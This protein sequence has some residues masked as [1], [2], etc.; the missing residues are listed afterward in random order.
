MHHTEP[1]TVSALYDY[2]HVSNILCTKQTQYIT[3]NHLQWVLSMITNMSQIYCV[4]NKH[5]T[6]HCTIYSGCSLWLR[7][8]LKYTLYQT[9]TIHHTEP[10][11]VSVLYDY[12]HVSNILCTKQ[13]QYITLNHLQW[14]F[15]MIT[16]M[17]Q[18][19]C[20]PNKHNT[21]HCTIYSGCSLWL[22]TCLK[23][24]VYQTNTIHHTEPFTVSVLYDY[25]HVSNILCTKQTQY[26]TLDHLQWV[27]SMITNMS[28]IHCVPNK[29][30]TSHWTIYSECSLWL[31]TCLKYTVYQ[32][33]TIH[34]TE[35]FTVSAL[36][37]YEHVS[38]WHQ[39][40]PKNDRK[41]GTAADTISYDR[42]L[43]HLFAL[44]WLSSVEYTRRTF[45][46]NPN[47]LANSGPHQFV[48]HSK[49]SQESF[50][51]WPQPI[52]DDVTR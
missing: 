36:Y 37:D 13:T 33:N 21:S 20:V 31:R 44:S 26:I 5:N 46:D 28:Q 3:L 14:V 50:W 32:T 4:P 41:K 48:L 39:N 1:F 42:C 27:F 7:T 34:H 43:H 11:T 8:C 45:H 30:Y 16:N 35:P 25:E 22:R 18:I 19:Y 9:N 49:L 2:E 29:H 10:F 6:S 52:R 38:V 17:S 15:S 23:Y 24:T 47:N 12:E 40:V 51:V